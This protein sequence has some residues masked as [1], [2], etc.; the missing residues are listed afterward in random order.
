M[1]GRVERMNLEERIKALEE[2]L[3]IEEEQSKKK[4]VYSLG[5]AHCSKCGM[6]TFDCI[7]GD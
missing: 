1:K 3:N 5:I 4:T 6:F 2:K 7:C